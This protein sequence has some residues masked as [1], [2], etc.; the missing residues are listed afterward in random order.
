MSNSAMSWTTRAAFLLAIGIAG[1]QAKW[2]AVARAKEPG[3]ED[4]AH[5]RAGD[6]I[7]GEWWTEGREGRLRFVR[8][9]DGTY[10]AITTC[11]PPKHPSA[12]HPARDIHNPNPNQRARSTIGIV[13]IWNLSYDE[14]EYTDGYVY[15]PRNGKTYR[16]EAELVDRN[17]LK[18][19][20]YL[21]IPLLGQT[22]IWK[23][24]SDR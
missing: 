18:I 8:H 1:A 2:P 23:R 3:K 14:G 24:Y 4:D 21:G 19:R 7:L 9:G 20:G 22:Q 10:R 13:L 15:N 17:T 5:A 6:G 16:F 11:C 12:D